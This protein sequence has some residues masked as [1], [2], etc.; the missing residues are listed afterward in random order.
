MTIACLS[1]IRGRSFASRPG[2]APLRKK[3]AALAQAR[4]LGHAAQGPSVAV[5]MASAWCPAFSNRAKVT[6]SGTSSWSSR[7]GP[8][9]DDYLALLELVSPDAEMQVYSAA[10]PLDLVDLALAV[11]FA[12]SLEGKQLRLPREQLQF[13]K[14]FSCCH[15]LRVAI[16]APS[17]IGRD[18]TKSHGPNCNNSS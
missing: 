10:L 5:H 7:G 14:Q 15:P 2:S 11:L 8:D 17:V 16:L 3:S 4:P 9:S 6:C 13:G 1:S 12:A 18:N